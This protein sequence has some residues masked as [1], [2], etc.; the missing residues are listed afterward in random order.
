M[1]TTDTIDPGD[2]WRDAVV[3][4]IYPR[5]FADSDGDGIGDI[6]GIIA[7]IDYLDT[8]G[9]DAVW[10]SPFYPSALA[11]GGYDV[12]DH[13]SVDPRLGSLEDTAELIR[14]LHAHG[15]RVFVDIV[16]NHSSD[17]HRWF[18]EAL[19]A[20][21]GSPQRGR[22]IFRDGQ[23]P[24]GAQ[25]PSDWPSRFG[26]SAWTRVVTDGTPEQWYLHLFSAQQPDFNWHNEEVREDFRATLRFWADLGVDGFRIDVAHALTK[27]LTEPFRSK[28]AIVDFD[29]PDTG[30]DVL[31]DRDD[32]HEIYR[33]WRKL[34]D[35]YAPKRVAVAE[36]AV[37]ASRRPLYCRP[38][39]LHQAFNFDLLHARYRAADFRRII[40]ENLALAAQ[41]STSS[42][43]V[44][45]NH[46][47]VRHATRY[48]LPEEA[49]LDAWLMTDGT[50]PQLNRE[51]GLRR[52]R[53]ATLLILALPGSVYL[54]QGEELGLHE[55][56][57]L[58]GTS[59]QDPI[60]AR[61]GRTI[62]GRDGCRVPLPWTPEPPGFG[63]T[64]GTPHLPMPAEFAAA[65]A[66]RE[67][68]ADASTLNLYRNALRIRRALPRTET[69]AWMTGAR[70]VLHFTRGEWNCIMN[71]STTPAPL[72]QGEGILG[73][74][75]I[76]GDLLPGETTYWY[77]PF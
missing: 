18:Q 67:D 33:D 21:P 76:D 29:N 27:D 23:G 10:L 13:R 35:E 17:R 22:Y 40:T 70:D 39:E 73:S 42:T 57:D 71:F 63:F 28:P 2:W 66:Q 46:D 51:Q 54:Y 8:L 15:I 61:T 16:P 44:L 26:G 60:W 72:P 55:V 9:V 31:F 3:Y 20:G 37:K 65:S 34:F 64:T 38:D 4:Q 5:S 62:K 74:R 49:D 6:P 47:I 43:W 7:H 14:A 50:S 48:G 11:D 53:A 1:T 75:G 41:T 77:R 59:I 30:D 36:A 32:V 12:D 25:P 68:T 56:A 58:P 45:S 69:F 19:A 52:A 24:D